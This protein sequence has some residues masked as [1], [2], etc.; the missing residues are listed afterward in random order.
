MGLLL[1][2]LEQFTRNMY[3]IVEYW[4]VEDLVSRPDGNVLKD[5]Q[6]PSSGEKYLAVRSAWFL[7]FVSE[8][9]SAVQ[10]CFIE[11]L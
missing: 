11:I 1:L 4:P 10:D 3:A 8:A 9:L 6:I 7:E 2:A 5:V